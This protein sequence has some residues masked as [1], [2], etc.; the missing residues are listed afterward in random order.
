MLP[1]SLDLT[2]LRLA[3]IGRDAAGIRR[4]AALDAA[5]ARVLNVY[6]PQPSPELAKAAGERLVA[7]WPEASDLAE[8][9]LV[10][11]AD[12]AEPQRSAVTDLARAAGAIVHV[13]DAPALTDIHAPAVLRRGDLTVAIST[14]GAA[15]GL[16]GELRQFLGGIFGPEW[17]GRV[18]ELRTLRQGWRDIG[19]SGATIRRLTAARI[20]RDGWLK[21]GRGEAANDKKTIAHERGGGSCL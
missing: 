16:A 15:P 9:Q 10:F 21:K 7:R 20:A 4:L 13:E 2:R 6:A 19:V 18:A 11:I 12:I 1:L 14:N 5:G 3:L 8:T 17:R